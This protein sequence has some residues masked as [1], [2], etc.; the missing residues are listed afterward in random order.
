MEKSIL[1]IEILAI[2]L[3]I[4]YNIAVRARLTLNH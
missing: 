4:V 3:P 2:I 1:P